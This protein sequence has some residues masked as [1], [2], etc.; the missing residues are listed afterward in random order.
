MRVQWTARTMPPLTRGVSAPGST[1]VFPCHCG[2]SWV[3]QICELNYGGVSRN[4][5][6]RPIPVSKSFCLQGCRGFPNSHSL[7]GATWTRSLW[8]TKRSLQ[9]PGKNRG[10]IKPVT[11]SRVCSRKPSTLAYPLFFSTTMSERRGMRLCMK[12]LLL[13]I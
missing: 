7:F 3:I 8:E 9:I 2:D 6:P 13:A 1:R 12:A 10:T 5:L 4:I 11:I